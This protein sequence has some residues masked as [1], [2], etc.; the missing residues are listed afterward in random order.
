MKRTSITRRL[1]LGVAV[2]LAAALVWGAATAAAASP[3]S[4]PSPAGVVLKVGWTSEPDNLNPFIGWAN[5]TYEI[6]ALNYDFLFDFGVNG[7]QATLDLASEWP[8]QAN[9][10][11]SPD[12]KVWTIHLRP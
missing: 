3:S 1:L 10:G 9:G 5:T 7:G 4:S 11:I 2:L 12:G 6:W 8:T